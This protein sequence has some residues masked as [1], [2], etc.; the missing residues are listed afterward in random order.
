M[1]P[2]NNQRATVFGVDGQAIDYSFDAGMQGN[3]DYHKIDRS[4]AGSHMIDSDT[5]FSLVPQYGNP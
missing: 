3:Y 1:S 2:Y 5:V 4:F